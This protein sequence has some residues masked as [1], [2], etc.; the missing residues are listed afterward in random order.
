[1][2]LSEEVKQ[3]LES[4]APPSAEVRKELEQYLA[5]TG[6][7]ARDFADACGY[8]Y[9]AVRFFRDDAYGQVAASDVLI[10]RAVWDFMKSHPVKPETHVSGKL[11]PTEDYRQLRKYFYLALQRRRAYVVQADPGIG[12]SFMSKHLIAELNRKE[13]AKN[14]AGRRAY[15]VRA[16]ATMTPIQLLREIAIAC[17]VCSVGESR[18]IVRALRRAFSGRAVL[19]VI[20]EA[21]Q[22]SIAA[23]E[24]VR[25]LLDEPPNCGLL[26]VGSHELWRKFTI[27]AIELEQW[28]SRIP[29][30]AILKGLT[31]EEGMTILE[32]EFPNAEKPKL[33][34]ALKDCHAVHLHKANRQLP[35]DYVSARRLFS[36]V[37]DVKSEAEDDD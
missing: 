13:M 6:M 5:V 18:R 21:Q 33:R 27:H 24:A 10:R 15:F 30:F 29:Q 14:G 28:N 11:Y 31:D 37:E 32:S 1:M 3:Q 25:E 12:K 9:S 17:G 23:L 22:L 34:K 4:Q 35:G 19:V 36:M 16:S 2:R 7:N 26:I 20:D 8:S